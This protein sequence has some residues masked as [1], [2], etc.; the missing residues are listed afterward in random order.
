MLRGS[1]PIVRLRQAVTRLARDRRGVSAVEFAMILPLMLTFYLGTVEVT[2]GINIYRK[3]E[4]ATRAAADLTTRLA[5]IDTTEMGNVL[6]AAKTMLVPYP[7]EPLSV[8]VS[9]VDIDSD[10]KAK[11]V[12]SRSL[13]GT[14][15]EKTEVPVPP[16]LKVPNTSLIW[17][18]V[19]YDYKPTIGYVISGTIKLSDN[20]YM[21][22]RL[23][24]KV[25]WK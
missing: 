4:V 12:W 22:P 23:S 2:Q 11:V 3:V 18:E 16:A 14:P 25:S 13:Q 1:A 20:I 8:T 24:D 19:K 21:R 6:N 7:T 5:Q 15:R 10:G 17:A 9:S